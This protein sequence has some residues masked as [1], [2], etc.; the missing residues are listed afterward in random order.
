MSIPK[1][2]WQTHEWDYKELPFPFKENSKNIPLINSGWEYRYI[3]A[4]TRKRMI[5]NYSNKWG[6]D[7]LELYERIVSDGSFYKSNGEAKSHQV[8]LWR[9]LTIYEYGGIYIDMDSYMTKSLNE[10]NLDYDFVYLN[11]PYEVFIDFDGK[12]IG[13]TFY[14]NHFF[15][16]SQKNHI[17]EKICFGAV[18]ILKSFQK[19]KI[20][21]ESIGPELFSK[22]IEIFKNSDNYKDKMNNSLFGLIHSDRLKYEQYNSISFSIK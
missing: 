14:S 7:L 17:M 8:D 12:R 3:N 4:E 18:T 1:I 21:A 11:E 15:G 16:A 10:M 9:Y 22:A 13:K 5:S 2:I 19:N 20:L 6:N